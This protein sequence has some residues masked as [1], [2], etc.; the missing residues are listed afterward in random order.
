MCLTVESVHETLTSGQSRLSGQVYQKSKTHVLVNF[1]IYQMIA[2]KIANTGSH[3]V[4][5]TGACKSCCV[6]LL[7]HLLICCLPCCCLIV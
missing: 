1:E 3:S 6:R 4:I 2:W 5:S 7:T